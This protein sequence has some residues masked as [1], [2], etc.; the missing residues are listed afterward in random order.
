[1]AIATGLPG[2]D[3]LIFSFLTPGENDPEEDPLIHGT[4]I[5]PVARD[6]FFIKVRL[7]SDIILIFNKQVQDIKN[8]AIYV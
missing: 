1:M 4:A 5:L 7:F 3:T 2:C 6:T 8:I